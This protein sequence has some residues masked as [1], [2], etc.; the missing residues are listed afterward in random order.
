MNAK[1]MDLKDPNLLGHLQEGLSSS[2]E[3]RLL[4]GKL[5]WSVHSST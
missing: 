3:V 4:A 2:A 1:D 5:A